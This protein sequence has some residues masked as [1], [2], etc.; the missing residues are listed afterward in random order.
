MSVPVFS[1]VGVA[2][3]T[4]FDSS[5]AVDAK[6]TADHA[7]RLAE[8]GVQAVL[9]AGSTGESASLDIEECTDLVRTVRAALPPQ[10]AVLA[11]GGAPSGRQAAHLTRVVLD[12]GADAVLAL[13]PPRSSDARQ[14]YE[15][16]A[17]AAQGAT[18][19]AYHFPNFSPPGIPVSVLADLPVA[20]LKDSSGDPHRLFEE[21]EAF[22]G[23]LYVGST[24][25]VLLAGALDCAGAILA[26]ANLE[27]ELS[28]RAFA[29]DAEAQRE[30]VVAADKVAGPWPHAL[31][32]AVAARFGTSPATRMG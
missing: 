4:I 3:L 16:V 32:G 13:S 10:V 20:G 12:A 8:H 5:G 24:N 18:V 29:G 19:L 15:L 17:E 14:Y 31:K 22:A 26:I 28:I 7:S 30:L 2:L 6:A 9:V 11:G 27:P 1:G 23:W 21:L 25:L